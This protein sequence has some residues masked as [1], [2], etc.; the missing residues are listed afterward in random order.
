MKPIILA[1]ASQR[2]KMLL[3][4]AGVSFRSRPSRAPEGQVVRTTVAA[5]VQGN[6]LAKA[7]D[8]AGRVKKGVV[9]AADT[10]VTDGRSKVLGKPRDPKEARRFLKLFFNRP[11][12]VYTGVAVIDVAGG[13]CLADHEK[14]KVFMTPLTD[15]EIDAYH[16]KN[17]PMDKAGGFNIEGQGGLFIRRIEGCYSNVIGLPM[18]KLRT[19]LK[20]CGVEIL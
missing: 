2:R 1:S 20:Q 12:W 15:R 11:H 19:M 17:P 18:A 16:R 9:I 3:R 6:A 8:V 5:L 13:L 14:T 7:R 4:E 10:V